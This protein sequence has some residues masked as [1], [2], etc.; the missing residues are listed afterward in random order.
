MSLCTAKKG[1]RRREGTGIAQ[2][3]EK[4]KSEEEEEE[5]KKD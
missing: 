3:C 4:E 1:K 2:L 5:K